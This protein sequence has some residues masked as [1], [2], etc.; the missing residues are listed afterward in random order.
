M[1]IAVCSQSAWSFYYHNTIKVVRE[2]SEAP[3]PLWN[4]HYPR[5]S[6]SQAFR[7][8]QSSH[9]WVTPLLSFNP[10]NVRS[11]CPLL[12]GMLCFG[13]AL[14]P[15]RKNLNSLFPSPSRRR[16]HRTVIQNQTSARD[17]E[18]R[19]GPPGCHSSTSCKQWIPP[20][21]FDVV[22]YHWL[23]KKKIKFSTLCEN[24][25]LDK[26]LEEFH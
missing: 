1:G 12:L 23:K 25:I 14:H 6:P 20:K 18:K 16:L 13:V 2:A 11:T 17:V 10:F 15:C 22:L 26:V 8:T 5:P 24:L 19:T 21:A 9:S 4:S 7:L 3:Q